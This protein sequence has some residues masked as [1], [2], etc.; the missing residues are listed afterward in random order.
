MLARWGSEHYNSVNNWTSVFV[1]G[2]SMILLREAVLWQSANTSNREL[3]QPRQRR[4]QEGHKFAY[5]TIKNN[6]FARFARAFFIFSHFADVLVRST[7]WND[8]FCSCVDDL[9]IWWQKFNFVF[10]S[11]KAWFQ[12][13]SRIVGTHFVSVM[14]LNNL[15]I[16]A[17]TR[18]YIF[19]WRFRCRQRRVC[20]RSLLSALESFYSGHLTLLNW[21]DTKLVWCTRL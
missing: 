12:F 9:S 3:K 2:N 14:T 10:L 19:R 1:R 13:N 18:S 7:T 8:L 6:S 5:L 11:L 17:E 20:L 15:K 21:F 4:Q 16:I